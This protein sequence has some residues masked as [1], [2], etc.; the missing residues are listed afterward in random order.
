MLQ[1]R[2]KIHGAAHITGGGLTD[3]IPRILPDNYFARIDL[4]SWRFPKIFSLIQEKAKLSTHDMLKTFNCGLG[5]VLIIDRNDIKE[6]NTI[7]TKLKYKPKLIGYIDNRKSKES[8]LY[9][10]N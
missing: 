5:M 3:N 7:A 2:I 1:K 8:I 6:L 9:E 4:S 10:K